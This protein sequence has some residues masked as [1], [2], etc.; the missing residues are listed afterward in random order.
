[1]NEPESSRLR[2]FIM[3]INTMA[4]PEV[5]TIEAPV[6]EVAAPFNWQAELESMIEKMRLYMETD[7]SGDFAYGVE[8][9][10][11][12]AADMIEGLLRR[13]NEGNHYGP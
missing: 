13:S 11:Q 6:E 8:S 7:G 4:E 3:L 1:M 5:E 12:L 10:M 2:H 9:G